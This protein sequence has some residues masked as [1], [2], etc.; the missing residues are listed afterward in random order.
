MKPDCIT[1]DNYESWFL[2]Y[3]EGN[4]EVN[5]IDEFLHFISLNPDLEEELQLFDH[6]GPEETEL[7]FSDKRKLYKELLDK[8]EVFEQTAVG[9]VG[10][11]L[12]EDELSSF[13]QYLK[14]YPSKNGDLSLFKNTILTP[15]LSVVFENKKLLYRKPVIPAVIK[16][17]T[18]IAAIVLL[19]IA[20]IPLIEKK[21]VDIKS[22]KF[23]TIY[24]PRNHEVIHPEKTL[25]IKKIHNRPVQKDVLLAGDK[26]AIA[27]STSKSSFYPDSARKY[28]P[29]LIA[30]EARTSLNTIAAN[31]PELRYFTFSPESSSVTGQEYTSLS[32]RLIKRTGISEIKVSRIIKWGLSLA[33]GLTNDKFKYS[34]D[35]AGEIIALNLDTRL[36]GFS[37]P[38]NRK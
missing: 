8:Q 34:T 6:V 10:G 13:V 30:S 33:T 3:L 29:P 27:I 25:V 19:C 9:Y 11:D 26:A 1:R 28:Y 7:N 31:E 2:D 38:I 36:L 17:L 35:S 16:M 4:L 23:L 5:R 12:N 24:T 14:K 15:D 32:D 21:P 22:E 37:I 18:R 20:V